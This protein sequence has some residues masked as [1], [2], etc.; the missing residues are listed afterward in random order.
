MEILMVRRYVDTP[1][2]RLSGQILT[3]EINPR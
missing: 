2:S 1:V 3:F